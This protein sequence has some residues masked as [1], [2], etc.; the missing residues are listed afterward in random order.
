MT[1]ANG[2]VKGCDNKTTNEPALTAG[3]KYILR[4][5]QISRAEIEEQLLEEI[6]VIQKSEPKAN[7]KKLQEQIENLKQKKRN[8]IDLVLDGLISKEDLAEQNSY[9][10][11]QIL[12]LTER[13]S[14]GRNTSAAHKKQLDKIREYIRAVRET[15]ELD[16]DNTELY[17]D[18]VIKIVV[19]ESKDERILEY[20]LNCVPFGFRVKYHMQKPN[21]YQ[22]FAI[23]I[24]SCTVI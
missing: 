13:I 3:A 21:M 23:I 12:Q 7:V 10:D 15:D 5:I 16:I 4:Q 20:Y 18:L 8:A 1:D 14:T 11:E 17:R 22:K 6:K 2:E 19:Y 24:D 9:Y